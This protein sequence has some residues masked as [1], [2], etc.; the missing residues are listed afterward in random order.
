[1]K[2]P[3]GG[4]WV[5]GLRAP[6]SMKSPSERPAASVPRKGR[7]VQ[8]QRSAFLVGFPKGMKS[9]WSSGRRGVS[10]GDKKPLG[11]FSPLPEIHK[12]RPLGVSYG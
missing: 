9:P 3:P 12:E 1:M 11:F 8:K 7:E 2:S 6:V 10:K 5:R 4:V